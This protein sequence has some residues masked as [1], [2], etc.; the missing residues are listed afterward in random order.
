MADQSS[1]GTIAV[2]GCGNI[3]LSVAK[4]IV[5]A[6]ISTPEKLIL[7]KRNEATLAHLKEEKYV[8]SSDNVDAVK[9]SQVLIIGVTPAQLNGLLDS[10]KDALVPGKHIIISIVSGAR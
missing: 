8:I 5:Y 6:N 4:G 9:K 2:L 1:V 3:G 7:T 10:I